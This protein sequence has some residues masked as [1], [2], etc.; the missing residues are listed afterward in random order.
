MRSMLYSTVAAVVLLTGAVG[1]QERA[2]ALDG[3]GSLVSMPL[4]E[5]T[6]THGGNL[7]FLRFRN[8]S[9]TATI[10]TVRIVG[11]PSGVDYLNGNSYSI[12]VPPHAAPQRALTDIQT[13]VGTSIM[14]RGGDS[15]ANALITADR[16]G[17]SVQHV[18]Y[19]NTTGYFENL[20]VCKDGVNTTS[21]AVNRFLGNVH[22]SRLGGYRSSLYV[23]NPQTASRAVRGRVYDAVS[24]SEIGSF[25]R[26]ARANELLKVAMTTLETELNFAPSTSQLHVNVRFETAD[27]QAFSSLVGHLVR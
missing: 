3:T 23:F 25:T 2:S 4:F 15:Y 14:T 8:D 6:A 13:A 1:A 16:S 10:F 26:T 19:N 27:S 5:N 9:D 7:S 20:T 22:T 18:M 11:S 21:V 17:A 12:T 24:G